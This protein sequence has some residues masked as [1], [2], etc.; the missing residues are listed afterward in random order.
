MFITRRIISNTRSAV[1]VTRY[2][3]QNFTARVAAL[4]FDSSSAA[5]AATFRSNFSSAT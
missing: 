3:V 1:S 5:R 2:L 4:R